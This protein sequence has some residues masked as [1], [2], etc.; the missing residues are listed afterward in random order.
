MCDFDL[1]TRIQ[2]WG[3]T[4]KKSLGDA[5]SK[6]NSVGCKYVPKGF[7]IEARLNHKVI[8]TSQKVKKARSRTSDSACSGALGS[9]DN[10]VEEDGQG[11]N[12]PVHHQRLRDTAKAFCSSDFDSTAH[13]GSLKSTCGPRHRD[14][15]LHQHQ[16]LSSIERR[17]TVITWISNILTRDFNRQFFP[18]KFWVKSESTLV[19]WVWRV[20]SRQIFIHDK[21]TR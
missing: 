10:K 3:W 16:I 1:N 8:R 7:V 20:K 4:V 5:K 19:I 13:R 12:R 17:L 11:R 14:W 21:S 6:K 9:S 18:Q 15:S 2:T